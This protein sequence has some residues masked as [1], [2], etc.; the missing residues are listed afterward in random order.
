MEPVTCYFYS[1]ICHCYFGTAGFYNVAVQRGLF[2]NLQQC[3][4][5]EGFLETNANNNE[6]KGRICCRLG[7]GHHQC[8]HSWQDKTI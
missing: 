2:C 1:L 4:S 8:R 3:C 6:K 5:N 7:V